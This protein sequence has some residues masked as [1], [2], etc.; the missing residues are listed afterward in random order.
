M[1]IE[2][3]DAMGRNVSADY[4]DASERQQDNAWAHG[5][6]RNFS[7]LV[8]T[9]GLVRAGFPWLE[10]AEPP[11]NDPGPQSRAFRLADC[12]LSVVRAG[13]SSAAGKPS[14]ASATDPDCV[15]VIWQ[16]AG[17]ITV[18]QDGRESA[19]SRHDLTFCDTSRPYRVQPA[20]GAAFAVFTIPHD[21]I[22]DWS[23]WTRTVCASR[24]R[25]RF[26]VR[27]ALETLFAGSRG[28]GSVSDAQHDLVVESI[29]WRLTATLAQFQRTQVPQRR[30]DDRFER[31]QQVICE[32]LSNPSLS[33]D[34]IAAA[35]HMSR[36]ALYLVFKK[37]QITP[38]ELIRDVRLDKAAEVLQG[39]D[40]SLR[41]ITDIAFD[42]GFSDCATFSRLFKQRFG[43]TPTEFRAAGGRSTPI[44]PER[45][46]PSE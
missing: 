46:T 1:R 20:P 9:N 16:I 36:R 11:E 32:Q 43:V 3:E 37:H 23:Q 13:E 24:L 38:A 8:V 40:C 31:A 42:F 33:A 14:M 7:R 2:E 6:P 30:P 45:A 5:A 10:Y 41:K 25:D 34:D 17:P 18:E 12:S 22:P 39:T 44:S 35:L 27:A 28:A 4:A 29:R 19:L 15:S 26:T 21:W